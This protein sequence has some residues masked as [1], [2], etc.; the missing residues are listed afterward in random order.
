L[1]PPGLP[2]H[3]APDPIPA[4][5]RSAELQAPLLFEDLLA[6]YLLLKHV[7]HKNPERKN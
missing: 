6:R 3:H 1:N 2:H 7:I 4:F 5:Q